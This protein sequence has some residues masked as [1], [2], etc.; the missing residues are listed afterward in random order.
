MEKIECSNL[1]IYGTDLLISA[2][3]KA[4]ARRNADAKL[5]VS[6]AV[7][8]TPATGADVKKFSWV[9]RGSHVGNPS[10]RRRSWKF[11]K[12]PSLHSE[13]VLKFAKMLCIHLG[14]A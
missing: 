8:R 10:E 1:L 6:G 13:E 14:A 7:R 12:W 5:V 11:A 9:G 2:D 3:Y 4:S